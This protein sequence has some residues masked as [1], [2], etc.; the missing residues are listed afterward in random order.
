VGE[1]G[2]KVSVH[3]Y[4]IVTIIESGAVMLCNPHANVSKALIFGQQTE[5]KATTA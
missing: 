1:T 3:Q 4:K 2:S 5:I